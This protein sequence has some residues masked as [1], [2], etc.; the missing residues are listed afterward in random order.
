M[1]RLTE[2]LAQIKATLQ[3][4]NTGL[5]DNRLLDLNQRCD[6]LNNS[7]NSIAEVLDQLAKFT[8]SI[9]VSPEE[10]QRALAHLNLSTITGDSL[11][12]KL[13]AI[14]QLASESNQELVAKIRETERE[15]E[16]IL[17]TLTEQQTLI[18]TYQDQLTTLETKVKLSENKAKDLALKAGLLG[19]GI[20]A[21]LGGLV[22]ILARYLR[23]EYN[24]KR[25]AY[26]QQKNK[27]RYNQDKGCINA[28]NQDATISEKIQ[29]I[30]IDTT[31][32][33]TDA[34]KNNTTTDAT[35]EVV[36]DA[37][38]QPHLPSCSRCAELEKATS[39]LQRK[40]DDCDKRHTIPKEADFINLI[41]FSMVALILA[42]L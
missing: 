38:I 1:D 6:S 35:K 21:S 9:E 12:A 39:R 7:L 41:L 29:P 10:T 40:I 19:A 18:T 8:T 34:T 23:R 14:L 33:T 3:Q 31:F 15:L 4:N 27:E 28:T 25:K 5:E 11:R 24:A 30:K 32:N 37:T 26:I 42:E 36:L 2:L 13:E 22:I 16:T 20:T 17:K